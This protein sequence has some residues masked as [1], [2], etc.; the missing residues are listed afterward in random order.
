MAV[1]QSE[2]SCLVHS[3]LIHSGFS[4]TAS[5]F[6]SEAKQCL[7]SISVNGTIRSLEH[8]LSEYAK[9][10]QTEIQKNKMQKS[11]LANGENSDYLMDIWQSFDS[12]IDDYKYFKKK[13]RQQN[14]NNNRKRRRLSDWNGDD[15]QDEKQNLFEL[16][17]GRFNEILNNKALHEKMARLISQQINDKNQDK[18][19]G[20]VD[21]ML[22]I[23]ESQFEQLFVPL[24]LD[25]FQHQKQKQAVDKEQT[26]K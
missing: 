3:W 24:P 21:Q 9:L 19:T 11:L 13:N 12:L 1:T 22:A 25:T 6:M 26:T 5:V 2:I 14:G 8:I 18:N 23:D 10:K 7:Q 15:L 17:T 16:N 20:V 4:K